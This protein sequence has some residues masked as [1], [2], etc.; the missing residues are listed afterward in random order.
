MGCLDFEVRDLWGP[1]DLDTALRPVLV[2]ADAALL[3]PGFRIGMAL[4]I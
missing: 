2:A 4:L 1:V 3:D